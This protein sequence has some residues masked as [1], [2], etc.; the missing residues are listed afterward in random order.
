VPAWKPDLLF[1]AVAAITGMD[2]KSSGSH[3]GRVK[4][5]LAKVDPPYTPEEVREFGRMF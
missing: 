3:I 4:S 1:D 5:L 2:P